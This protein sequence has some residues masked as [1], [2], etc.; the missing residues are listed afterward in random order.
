M[1]ESYELAWMAVETFLK[2][3]H[4]LEKIYDVDFKK[5]GQIGDLM[6]FEAIICLVE[7]IFIFVKKE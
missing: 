2:S 1:R 5:S 6:K 3:G 4:R 7:V